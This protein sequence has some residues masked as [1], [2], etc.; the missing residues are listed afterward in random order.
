MRH[1]PKVLL[2]LLGLVGL[3]A[4]AL[5]FLWASTYQEGDD[6]TLYVAFWLALVVA[7]ALLVALMILFVI[8]L[9]VDLLRWRRNRSRPEA[10]ARSPAE[11]RPR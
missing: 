9:L 7:A 11:R 4:A 10:P 2:N 1:L 6:T 5:W 8:S 3:F